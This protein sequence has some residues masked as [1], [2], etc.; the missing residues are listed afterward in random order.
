MKK[1][2]LLA[3][4]AVPFIKTGG[5]ADVAGSL[6]AALDPKEADIRVMLPDY[7]CIRE[8][9]RKDFRYLTHFN[10]QHMG[11][12]VYAG[13]MTACV[14]S[15]RFY[16]VDNEYYFSGDKPYTSDERWDI[17]RFTFF[18]KAAL[19]ALKHIGFQP[20]VLHLNDWQTAATAVFLKEFYAGDPF[21]SGMKTLLTI[22]N[23]KFQGKWGIAELQRITG[24]PSECFV[25]EKLEAWG[26]ASLLKGG[27]S[28]ADAVNTVSMSYA[29]E[30]RTPEYGEGLD[31]ILRHRSGVLSGIV[32]GIDYEGFDPSSDRNL[33]I[34]YSAEDFRKKKIK[35]KLALQKETG[36]PQDA[37]CLLLGMV[38]RLTEQKGLDLLGG[39][40]DRLLQ[41]RV[42]LLV[43]GNGESRFED[44]FRYYAARYPDKLCAVIS[45]SD[46]LA[47][48]I[49][50]GTD[51]FLMP[52]RFEPCGLSQLIA[53]RYGSLPIVR[54]TGG[55]KDT[56]EPYN[57][58]ENKGTGFSFMN[59]DPE[60]LLGT[61][62]YAE[63]VFFGHKAAWNRI[64][65]RA[66]R[67]DFSWKNSAHSYQELYS[68][69]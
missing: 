7:R 56:V 54:E 24:L 9:Y 36:L 64:A 65:E 39:I 53:L 26:A 63:S 31:S 22:H 28:Y 6:P 32:N 11:R 69:L 46:P 30:I 29:Q 2:L 5:L 44:M 41:E 38:S 40:L 43:L 62:H 37:H 19:E 52:S 33:K 35:N 47:R 3:S 4:E 59:Y 27:I 60:D 61:I 21:Y 16:F 20:D 34:N 66:M 15:I 48:R 17:E 18:D 51:A 14:K 25:P 67:Q 13:I 45:Y 1:I 12:E 49:Y 10:V 42:Q 57:E 8:E 50:A 23:L 55:L 58:Y 68:R